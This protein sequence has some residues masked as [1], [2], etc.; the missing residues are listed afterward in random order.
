MTNPESG[1]RALPSRWLR[2]T[3]SMLLHAASFFLVFVVLC[4]MAAGMADYYQHAN[5]EIPD[6]TYKVI[7]LSEY[8]IRFFLPIF[9]AVML[10][11][12]VFMVVWTSGRHSR[13]WPLSIYSQLFVFFALLIV[14]YSSIWLCNPIIWLVPSPLHTA[15]AVG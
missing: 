10:A 5:I 15:H 4:N 3:G 6:A 8:C 9:V 7:R 11:D 2:I 13:H 12:L 14:V 1:P